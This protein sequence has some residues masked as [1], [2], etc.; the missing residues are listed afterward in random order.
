M[1]TPRQTRPL[2][3]IRVETPGL[4]ADPNAGTPLAIT[5]A[6]VLFAP[7]NSVGANNLFAS[8]LGG[9][10]LT[11]QMWAMDSAS[12]LWV[13]IGSLLTLT[14]ASTATGINTAFSPSSNVSRYVYVQAITNTGS[15]TDLFYGL[16]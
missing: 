2:A 16:I 15:V 8:I 6:R 10:T 14:A 1:D 7:G 11:V 3:F 12:G 13:K 4:D 9:T 5:S